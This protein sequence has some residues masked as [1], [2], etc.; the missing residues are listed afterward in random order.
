[1]ATPISGKPP[2]A[3]TPA[4]RPGVASSSAPAASATASA[5]AAIAADGLSQDSTSFPPLYEAAILYSAEYNDAAQETL[6][7]YLKTNDGKNSIRAWLMMFDFYQITNNRKEFDALS[8]LFTVKFERSPPVWTDTHD[9]GD[10]RRKEKRERK[11]FFQ[12]TPDGDGALLGE[13][14]RFEGF[15]KE[16]GTVRLDFAKVKVILSEEAEL[17]AIVFQRLRRA[18]IPVWFNGFDDFAVLL[19]KHINDATGLPLKASQGFWSLLFEMYILDG[20][21]NEYEE[22][23]LEYAVAFEVS[24]PAWVVVTRPSAADDED[25]AA[26]GN[27][28]QKA[29]VGFPLAGVVSI[30]S[31]DVLQQLQ[32]YAAS[33]QEVVIDTADLLRLDFSA[34][35]MFFEA[36]RGIHLSQ[37]RVILSNL[38]ELVASLLEV[39]GLGKHA[40]LMRKKTA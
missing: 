10:P 2:S 36:V 21:L 19:K 20:K 25:A 13:I 11:D 22:L 18:K 12:M 33:K 38:N 7:E 23:G 37:K 6:K 15:A 5:N 30:G 17:F 3:S 40:I 28:T 14:D 34:V 31:K 24:P 35:T 8:M 4:S 9:A 26:K 39:F 29:A 27:A 16:L 32:I 1:M